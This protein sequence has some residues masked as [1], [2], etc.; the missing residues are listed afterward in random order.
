MFL[1]SLKYQIES[2]FWGGEGT[3]Y[4]TPIS[5]R[6][7]LCLLLGLLDTLDRFRIIYCTHNFL[8][9]TLS[10]LHLAHQ[11]LQ[12]IQLASTSTALLVPVL[13]AYFCFICNK[14]AGKSCSDFVVPVSTVL[15]V[16]Q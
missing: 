10:K 11:D 4:L 5:L 2:F 1:V 13:L 16:L 7:I 3:R 8:A 14:P 15:A 6:K 9:S 12:L